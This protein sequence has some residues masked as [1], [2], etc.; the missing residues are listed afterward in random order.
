MGVPWCRGAV[1]C[2]GAGNHVMVC[3]ARWLDTSTPK[4]HLNPKK[5][6]QPQKVT[7]TL[8]SHLNPKKSKKSATK[9][10]FFL[11]HFV[12][13]MLR[14][15]SIRP[16]KSKKVKNVKKDFFLFFTYCVSPC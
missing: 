15:C 3:G 13:K 10:F 12:T 16:K 8:K 2:Q 1:R 7:S 5:S 11:A 9:F 14:K 6:P 4:S